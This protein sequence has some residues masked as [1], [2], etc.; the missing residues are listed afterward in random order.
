MGPD[1]ASRLVMLPAPQPALLVEVFDVCRIT[2]IRLF[3]VKIKKKNSMQIIV[4]YKLESGISKTNSIW[5][6]LDKFGANA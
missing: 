1:T 6:Q 5:S 2:V 3:S 4:P